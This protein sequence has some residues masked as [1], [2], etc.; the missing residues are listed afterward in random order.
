MAA[1]RHPSEGSQAPPAQPSERRISTW[2]SNVNARPGLPD[3]PNPRRT[4][5]QKRA[6]DEQVRLVKEAKKTAK[7]DTYQETSTLQAQMVVDQSAAVKDQ[8]LFCICSYC[9]VYL[10]IT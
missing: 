1:S 7:Q 10:L 9:T 8:A 3:K 4:S 5:E 2:P 6:D